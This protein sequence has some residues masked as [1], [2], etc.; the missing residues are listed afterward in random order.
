MIRYT[1][2]A[3]AALALATPAL[4]QPENRTEN[5]A[6]NRHPRAQTLDTI[7]VVG[8]RTE[9]S[10]KD[11]P[12]SVAVVDQEQIDR[13]APESIAELIRDVPGIEV[14]DAS[15][16]GMKR[17][18]IRGESS[19]RVTILIDGQEVTDHSTYGTP[20]LVAPSNV[21]RIEI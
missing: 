19:R 6:S 21:E 16:P 4:A 9:T 5:T 8:T 15:V 10:I 7:T 18:R 14:V 1:M 17:I 11:N 20:L 13:R 3:W 12:A 2:L